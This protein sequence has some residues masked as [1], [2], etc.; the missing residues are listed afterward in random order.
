MRSYEAD[1]HVMNGK[2]NHYHQPVIIALDVEDIVLSADLR[3]GIER[4]LDVGKVTPLCFLRLFCP[5]LKSVFD[6]RVFG[7]ILFQGTDCY[8]SHL[9]FTFMPQR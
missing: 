2:L 1:I 5:L 9:V 7:V 6:L 3:H 4:L 8:N